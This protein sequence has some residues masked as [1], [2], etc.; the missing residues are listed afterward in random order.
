MLLI[1]CL[2]NIQVL[3]I[4]WLTSA[5]AKQLFKDKQIECQHYAHEHG[6]DSP[7]INDWVWPYEC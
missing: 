7:E 4:W 6:I 5:H 3:L 2:I 1:Q